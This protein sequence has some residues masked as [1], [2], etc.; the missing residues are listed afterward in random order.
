MKKSTFVVASRRTLNPKEE[1]EAVDEDVGDG[2]GDAGV[3]E[4]VV[5]V[6][7]YRRVGGDDGGA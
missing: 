7:Y 3:D 5:V 6:S 2:V 1:E 4:L